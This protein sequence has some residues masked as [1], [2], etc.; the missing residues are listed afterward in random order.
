MVL[1]K[2]FKECGHLSGYKIDTSDI[3]A[4][5]FVLYNKKKF[6]LSNEDLFGC[7][8]AV[9]TFT[10]DDCFSHISEEKKICFSELLVY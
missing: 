7:D 6:P 4:L 3:F 10:E 9:C 1:M 5:P 8:M 2:V